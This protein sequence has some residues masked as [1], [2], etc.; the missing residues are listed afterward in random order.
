VPCAVYVTCPPSV[1]SACGQPIAVTAASDVYAWATLTVELL[2]GRDGLTWRG[3]SSPDRFSFPYRKFVSQRCMSGGRPVI[4]RATPEPVEVG[5][6]DGVF[7]G[8]ASLPP[9]S[10]SLRG[11]TR[12]KHV[13]VSVSLHG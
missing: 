1:L 6:V 4:P 7:R 11:T 9:A 8:V 10:S 12:G 3:C 2:G 13:V 5:A